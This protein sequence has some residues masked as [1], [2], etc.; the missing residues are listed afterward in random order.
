M[1]FVINNCAGESSFENL[2]SLTLFIAWKCYIHYSVNEF[3]L[4]RLIMRIVTLN[5]STL[6]GISTLKL[7]KQYFSA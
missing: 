3:V 1:F 6:F 5:G 4:G 7:V 2:I